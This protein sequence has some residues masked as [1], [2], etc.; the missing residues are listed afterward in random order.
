MNDPLGAFDRVRDNFLLYVKTA[1]GTRFPSLEMERETLLLRTAPGHPGVFHQEPWLEP[2]PRYQ[3]A[4]EIGE[5]QDDEIAGLRG[6]ELADFKTLA[7]CGLIGDYPLFHHQLEML[8]SVFASNRAVVT[9]GTGAGKTE[10]FL[11]PLFAYLAQESRKWTPPDSVAPTDWWNT[12]NES[13]TRGTLK[14]VSQ[15]SGESAGRPAAVRALILYPM[16]ALVEDQ[17]TRLRKALDSDKARAWLDSSSGRKGNRITFGRYNGNTP[18]A[19]HEQIPDPKNPGQMKPN[20]A[21][22]TDLREQLRA[23]ERASE[24]A[25]DFVK[26]A[27]AK[28][29]ADP[30]PENLEALSGAEEVPFFFPRLDGGEMRSR[31][32][33]H[34]APPDIL[35]T[36]NSMLSIALM[37]DAEAALWDKT[38]AWLE[39]DSSHIF[40][41][42]IDE[43][44]LYRGTAGT[45]VAYLLRLLLL[46]LGLHP[47]HPQLRIL[48][49]SAS[50][51]PNETKSRDFLREFFGV[52][53]WKQE[54]IIEGVKPLAPPLPSG[55]LPA[56]PFIELAHVSD[57][58][59]SNPTRFGA[60]CEGVARVFGAPS[61]TGEV[62]LVRAFEDA[63]NG[64]GARIEA[65]CTVKGALRA[66]SLETFGAS[67]WDAGESAENRRLA[68]RGFLIARGLCLSDA[69]PSLR[70][71]WFFRNVEGLWA[72]T[73][74]S[75]LQ[76]A[77]GRAAGTLYGTSRIYE[78]GEGGKHRVLEL[79][80]CECCGTT[81]FGGARL[82]LEAGGVE[83]LNTDPEIEGIPD[84][85]GTA[86]V[87]KRPFSDYV[88][89]WPKG[90]S[91]RDDAAKKWDF[92]PDGSEEGPG[93]KYEGRWTK[94]SLHT[95]TARVTLSASGGNPD[96]VD[97]FLY[98][99]R[100]AA[101][102]TGDD[103]W[104]KDVSAFPAVCPACAADYRRRVA[105]KSPIRSFR[106]GFA[107]L[108]QLLSKELF[109]LL[110]EKSRKLV[111]FSDSR[112]DA[113]TIS[114][115]I[116]RTHY[117]DL[118]REAMYE[119]L[120]QNAVSEGRFL[121]ELPSG[122]LSAESISWEAG[123]PAKAK[124]IREDVETAKMPLSPGLPAAFLTAINDADARL[125][126]IKRRFVERTV[127]LRPLIWGPKNNPAEPDQSAPG[128]LLEK[129]KNLGVNPAGA[130]VLYQEFNW[131]GTHKDYRFWAELFRFDANIWSS[132]APEDAIK[133][134]RR[135]AMSEISEVIWSRFY[136]GFECAGL[137]FACLPLAKSVWQSEA[138]AL[139]VSAP[140]LE[141]IVTST[142][143]ILGEMFR[144]D[145]PASPYPISQWNPP[146][147]T[148]SIGGKL[149]K[150][151]EAVASHHKI[152]PKSL[153]KTVWR[154]VH[155]QGKQTHLILEPNHLEVRVA[156]G[157]D[158]IWACGKCGCEHLHASAGLCT[159]CRA[160][161]PVAS[162]ATCAEVH[163]RNYYATE[164]TRFRSPLR[165]HCE[166][167]SAQT[168]D[169]AARQRLFR[170]ITV[171]PEGGSR[172][173]VPVVDGIDLLSVT[174]TMEV[175][176]DIGPLQAVMLA[177]MPP[178][179][180]N[181]QQ[182]VGRAG[183]RKQAFAVVLTLCRGRSHDDHYY[184][185]PEKITGDKP[186]VPFLS[187]Q[188]EDIARRLL[189]KETL[190]QAFLAADVTWE[191][192][193]QPPDSHGEWGEIGAYDGALHLKIKDWLA[194][195]P[196]VRGI[197]QALAKES[198]FDAGD[199][200]KWGRTELADRVEK[201]VAQ[202]DLSAAGVATRLAEG[203][204]LPMFG[205]PS[206]VRLLYHGLG[207]AQTEKEAKSIDRDLEMA[208]SD[209]AP[210]AQ[211]TKDKRVLTAIGFTA[212][213]LNRN[214]VWKTATEIFGTPIISFR[215]WMAR[216]E[217][218]H[219]TQTYPLCPTFSNCPDCGAKVSKGTAPGRDASALLHLFEIVTPA[220][221]RTNL[222]RGQDL[223]DDSGLAFGGAT[224]VAEEDN[225][226]AAQNGA[227]NT[228]SRLSEGG[229]VFR[230]NTRQ[231]LQFTGSFGQAFRK[232]SA[233]STPPSFDSQWIEKSFAVDASTI[234]KPDSP[235]AN[236][237]AAGQSETF[238]LAA[239]KTTDVLR[240]RPLNTPQGL[241]LDPTTNKSSIKAAFY[242]A[243][244]LLRSVAAGE[245][246]I[247]PE[248]I[249]IANVRRSQSADGSWCGEI[250]LC[251]SLPNGAGFTRWMN[252]NWPTL[253]GALLHPAPNSF[254][255]H[256][257]ST[258]HQESCDSSCP[259]C[260]R[261]YRN[262]PFHG[263]LDWRLGLA[264]LR[265]YADQ[266]FSC[267]LDGDFSVPEL[268]G[269]SIQCQMLRNSFCSAFDDCKAES[270]TVR[271][272]TLSGWSFGSPSGHQTFIITHPLWHQGD[273]EGL[274]AQLKAKIEVDNPGTV[275][276]MRDGFN[277]ARRLSR[278][279]QEMPLP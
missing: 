146:P 133:I 138:A 159:R 175:G 255:A 213:L 253:L 155:T 211:K 250:I 37:R 36:N 152:A 215:R 157:T 236:F 185:F 62:A 247:D 267:G 57:D 216:C 103:E 55:F 111:V 241:Q 104:K 145:D 45:E 63:A 167:L 51:E 89:F 268:Q 249:A 54:Q 263:L 219:F 134:L 245:L 102:T 195:S 169:Q 205:M 275:V 141:E 35:I 192:G 113:A 226:L 164:A 69:L 124:Q 234:L 149:L 9:A 64:I 18:V 128:A 12:T 29:K 220:A 202:P 262:M 42:I 13:G 231:G 139:G 85:Q 23:A 129:L 264:T 259:E 67:L 196:E 151:L 125:S 225:S 47:D 135:K 61:G 30:T 25:L 183:R 110:P 52:S 100:P 277:L 86:L 92:A 68:S 147:G 99:L 210:G 165:L 96:C 203:A 201:T 93:T 109:Y 276:K 119:I 207:S 227:T 242:S 222:S 8:K 181:Y 53:E 237:S 246:D 214:G 26:A 154:I 179:R 233:S 260:L 114:N 252:D 70:L 130:D 278:V 122:V 132:G 148:G 120:L 95:P 144:Y 204:V 121:N 208:I 182:R 14:R 10:A 238:S 28:A 131:P 272:A 254:A 228:Q 271:G 256:L 72:S 269:W 189:A 270:W 209:F 34:D 163:A 88:L 2:M 105:R 184:Q 116:E 174:T 3:S 83:I 91:E 137:G 190:R 156:I 60:A 56:E 171:Q 142:L 107:R 48:A 94:A 261:H 161:L 46:R 112:E 16:N 40:H 90:G 173:L 4:K 223:K 106:T 74:V 24:A 65:A 166:E 265:V 199:L 127:P 197:A 31:W 217:N 176:V 117:G 240:L 229:S 6:E 5:L 150:W 19:G 158:P 235:L 101:G 251:D 20:S 168:D 7:S 78:A 266:S 126:D 274:L 21:K 115:G 1:F 76:K 75:A 170:D 22:L 81:L 239:R 187:M 136:F 32:D 80:R 87:E 194:A 97:G 38:R 49:S 160:P 59:I 66:V 178:M 232:L 82:E 39:S 123:E 43:L 71:H 224:T 172:D 73:Q 41:L 140:V 153:L 273:P 200:E 58:R 118:V 279:Y 188:R 258:G 11:L 17:L 193:P 230:L 243:A 15:R 180:F 212:P 27:R 84:R 198:G 257:V 244:F 79:L 177:N 143:R 186:P 98:S 162:N 44:H 33:M 108:S 50:L 221:F 206:R 218:C 191:Q 248:E 77:E